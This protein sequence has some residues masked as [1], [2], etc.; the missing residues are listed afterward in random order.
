MT[1]SCTDVGRPWSFSASNAGPNG[2]AG[3]QHV[4]DQHDMGAVEGDRQFGDAARHDR[5]QPD[6]VAVEADIERS[7]RNVTGAV[8]AA[9]RISQLLGDPHAAPLQSHE[10]HTV[11]AVVALDDLVS[12]AR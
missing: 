9:Q 8:D 2:A 5:S 11:G 10:H 7:H 4:V 12:D 3:E 6:V 1:A